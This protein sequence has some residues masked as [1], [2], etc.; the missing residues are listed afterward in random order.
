MINQDAV[1]INVNEIIKSKETPCLL[2]KKQ[3]LL[4]FEKTE[5]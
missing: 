5:P 2:N 1:I 3:S 4:L